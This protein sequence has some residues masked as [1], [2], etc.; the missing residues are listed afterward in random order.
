MTDH[1]DHAGH[2]H[3][4]AHAG[5]AHGPGHSHAPASFGKAFAIGIALNVG[6]VVVE[7]TY[8]VLANSMALLADAGH[9]LSDVL[10][11][12]VAWVAMVLAKRAPS[13]RYTYGMKGSSILAALFNAVFLLVAVG[14]IA[15]EAIQRFGEPAPVAGKTVMVVA[16]VG[17]LVNGITAWLFASGAKG[18]INIKGAF[19]HMAADAAVSA[20]VV[21][22]GLVILYTGW[23][24]LDPVVSLAIVAVIVWSTWGLLRDSLTLSLAAVP[25]G[26]DPAAVRSHLEGLPGVTALHDL[27]IWAM[28]T[29]ETCLTAHLIMPGG[30]PDDA[31][32]M[33]AAGGIKKRFGIGH[34]TLQVETSADNA[35]A[36]APDHVV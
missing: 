15:W 32:L 27:H 18:D 20:G 6:F 17:I 9:N 8:G 5:H 35:C 10:G 14:A 22:A 12:V 11:L 3:S 19:L 28:S 16:A 2:D 25:P 33:D 24:W 34:T 1:H 21:I 26:I 13:A 29:T 30:R 7:A 23:T 4:Q 31:F 36:L